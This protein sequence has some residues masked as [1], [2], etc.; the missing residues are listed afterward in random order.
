MDD[1]HATQ[2][3][4]WSDFVALVLSFQSTVEWCIV[5]ILC[6]VLFL[7]HPFHL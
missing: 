5:K 7:F 6:K 3:G 1:S 4:W 2:A